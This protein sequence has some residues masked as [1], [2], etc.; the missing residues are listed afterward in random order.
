MWGFASAHNNLQRVPELP[1]RE[2]V[3]RGC[4]M[5][6]RYVSG[7]TKLLRHRGGWAEATMNRLSVFGW[8]AVGRA[9]ARRV[10]WSRT[11]SAASTGGRYGGKKEKSIRSVLVVKKPR[12][13]RTTHAA[14]EIIR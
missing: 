9:S 11:F 4:R 2:L 12:D 7:V 5:P 14:G 1:P 6:S 13:E 10:V 3:A 8:C